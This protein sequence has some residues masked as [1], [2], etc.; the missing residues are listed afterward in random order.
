MIAHR[1]EFKLREE[2][3]A[4]VSERI[5]KQFAEKEAEGKKGRR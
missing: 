3:A 1:R 5:G 4:K 2:H